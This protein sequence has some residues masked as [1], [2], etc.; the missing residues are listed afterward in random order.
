MSSS[1]T[2]VGMPICFLGAILLILTQK[3]SQKFG[4]VL[5]IMVLDL[6]FPKHCVHKDTARYVLS[7]LKPFEL[8]S[9]VLARRGILLQSRV[10]GPT[11]RK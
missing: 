9:K 11:Y 2:G 3:S 1:A 5:G 7:N 6:F 8:L 10:S 4:D